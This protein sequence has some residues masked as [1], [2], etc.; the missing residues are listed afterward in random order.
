KVVGAWTVGE[1]LSLHPSMQQ[2]TMEIMLRVVFG[3]T[4][5]P[6][7]V[8]LRASIAALMTRLGSPFGLLLLAPTLERHFGRMGPWTRL[9][10]DIKRVDELLHAEIEARRAELAEPSNPRRNDVLSLLLEARDEHGD[11]MTDTELRDE[12]ITLLIAGYENTATAMC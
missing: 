7:H 5:R 3:L 4:E 8:E 6:R 11:G 9:Q 2:I 10:R 12:L 1:E